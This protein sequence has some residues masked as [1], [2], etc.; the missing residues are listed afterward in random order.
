M[1]DRRG[2]VISL[3]GR[4]GAVTEQLPQPEVL[5]AVA[6]QLYRLGFRLQQFSPRSTWPPQRWMIASTPFRMGLVGGRKRLSDLAMICA[7]DGRVLDRPTLEL[8]DARR[9]AER[10]LHD[11]AACLDTLQRADISP[12]ERTRETE[13]FVSARADALEVLAEIRH[14]IAQRL[15]TVPD[16]S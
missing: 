10:R 4:G 3:P 1:A 16:A 6:G 15:P 13:E 2:N 14:L 5:R 7:A 8:D 12:A 11:I 9:D